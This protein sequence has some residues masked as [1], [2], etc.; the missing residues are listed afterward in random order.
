M[1]CVGLIGTRRARAEASAL[2][3]P[4][5]PPLPSHCVAF[6]RSLSRKFGGV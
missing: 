1:D 6:R 5:T 3:L 2:P 4:L